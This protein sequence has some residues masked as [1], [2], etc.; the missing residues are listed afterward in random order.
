MNESGSQSVFSLLLFNYRVELRKL[1]RLYSQRSLVSLQMPSPLPLIRI[2][3]LE[4]SPQPNF[5]KPNLS[6]ALGP[7]HLMIIVMPSISIQPHSE[8]KRPA[9]RHRRSNIKLLQDFGA[10]IPKLEK[11][12]IVALPVCLNF[13]FVPDAWGDGHEV[14]VVL[15]LLC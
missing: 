13:D 2:R 9:I 14:V 15:G 5:I 8:L 10:I 7:L 4:L 11:A 3:I 1:M 12:R 6:S